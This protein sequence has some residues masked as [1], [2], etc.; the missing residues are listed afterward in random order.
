MSRNKLERFKENSI[1]RN[2]VE[3]GKPNFGKLA[4]KWKTEH[5]KN[6]KMY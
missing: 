2:V 4:G 1:H 6:E 5:F 3:L